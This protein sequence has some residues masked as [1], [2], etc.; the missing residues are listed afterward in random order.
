LSPLDLSRRSAIRLVGRY[1]RIADQTVTL[2]YLPSDLDPDHQTILVVSPHPDDAEIAAYGL[3]AGRNAYVVTITAGEAGDTEA[4]PG[5][6]GVAASL[7]KG[8]T[9]VWNSV[10]VPMLGGLAPDRMANLGYF[11]G[12]LEAMAADPAADM[13]S[14]S[15]ASTLDEFRSTAAQDLIP[16]RP[17]RPANQANLVEDLAYIVRRVRPDIIVAPYPLIDVHSDHKMTTMALIT[18]LRQI[19]WMHG[20]L[21]L[22]SNHLPASPIYPYGNAG[23][24]VSLPPGGG[25]LV[26]D[27]LYSN[28]LSSEEQAKKRIALEAMSDL[29]PPLR[30]DS[31]SSAARLALADLATRVNGLDISYFRRAVRADEFFMEIRMPSLFEPGVAERIEGRPVG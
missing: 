29:R 2:D 22:Y 23:D 31:P 14:V 30:A 25:D 5:L 9:R 15:G 1:L 17:G 26:F 11:D 27:G 18:A 21:L 19:R 8:H 6:A 24:V 3:Y 16:T 13:H 28:S 20:A 7:A 12:T 10:T 4:Y